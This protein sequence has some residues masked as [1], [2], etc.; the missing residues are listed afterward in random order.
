[1]MPDGLGVMKRLDCSGHNTGE[2]E[3]DGVGYK[4]TCVQPATPLL[5]NA[6]CPPGA[7]HLQPGLLLCQRQ[8]L[9]PAALQRRPCLRQVC[10]LRADFASLL[11]RCR[12]QLLSPMLQVQAPAVLLGGATLR[13]SA[14]AALRV[15]GLLQQGCLGRV[16]RG[17]LLGCCQQLQVG[18]TPTPAFREALPFLSFPSGTEADALS[19]PADRGQATR[20]AYEAAWQPVLLAGRPTWARCLA[21]CSMAANLS[22]LWH[23]LSRT[24]SSAARAAPSATAARCRVACSSS[25]IA[26]M[27]HSY[28]SEHL[29]GRRCRAGG[30][31]GARA[32]TWVGL[33]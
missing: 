8:P 10:L 27:M 30:P 32:G 28:I 13:G 4:Q 3:P 19:D 25:L 18:G 16:P 5:C 31:C 9:R 2:P 33:A 7:T 21:S 17:F 6:P 29:R 11:R 14:Q 20:P 22:L 12:L 15:H 24:R 1:M 23:M 26:P